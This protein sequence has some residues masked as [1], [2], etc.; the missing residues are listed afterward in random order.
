MSGWIPT[1]RVI[2]RTISRCRTMLKIL[3]STA[4]I[5]LVPLDGRLSSQGSG[6]GRGMS[7]TTS[8][9]AGDIISVHLDCDRSQVMFVYERT[10]LMQIIRNLPAGK[11][12]LYICLYTNGSGSGGWPDVSLV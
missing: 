12:F 8:Y 10:G 4:T 2:T 3:I 1:M 7:P 9:S 6:Y 5:S 11:Y